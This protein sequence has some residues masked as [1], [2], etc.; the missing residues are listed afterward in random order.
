MRRRARRPRRS[1]KGSVAAD[2]RL[3]SRRGGG[4]GGGGGGSRRG[5]SRRMAVGANVRG[6]RVQPLLAEVG[7]NATRRRPPR[8]DITPR[9]P[10]YLDRRL[11]DSAP[12]DAAIAARS[13]AAWLEDMA[14]RLLCLLSSIVSAITS[15][16]RGGARSRDW[17]AGAR[18]GSV[19]ASTRRRGGGDS[20]GVGVLSRPEWEVRHSALLALRYVLAAGRRSRRGSFLRRFRRR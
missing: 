15:V 14:V 20:R 1:A 7:K 17:R 3:R 8:C 18:R 19:A 10:A 12:E 9:T 16:T 2:P 11:G 5:G 4:G 6:A 13:N